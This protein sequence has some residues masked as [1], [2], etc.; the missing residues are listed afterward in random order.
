M[1]QRLADALTP[2]TSAVMVSA[3]FYM[4]GKIVQ[5]IPQL[6]AAA[7]NLDIP[8]LIDAY[9]ALGMCNNTIKWFYCKRMY[10]G[11]T[12][13]CCTISCRQQALPAGST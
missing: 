10:A 4:T 9:H 12:S 8:L 7:R 3:V 13:H 5:H 1:A 2:D 6:A 11:T